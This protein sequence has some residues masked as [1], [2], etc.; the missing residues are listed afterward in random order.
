VIAPHE[1]TNRHVKT[2]E[3]WAAS[4]RLTF[5]RVGDRAAS[6]ADVIV[7]DR[8]GVLGDLYALADIA[9]VGGGFRGAGLHS[10]LETTAFGAPVIIGPRNDDNRDARLLVEVGGA[11][12]DGTIGP[13]GRIADGTRAGLRKAHPLQ[14]KE[15]ALSTIN[16][17]ETSVHHL[18]FA[19]GTVRA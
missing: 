14:F 18:S 2:I 19:I 3:A 11:R 13:V 6:S 15:G 4:R 8:Y 16:L 17:P 10:L 5:A 7:V 1:L 9:Y 12:C